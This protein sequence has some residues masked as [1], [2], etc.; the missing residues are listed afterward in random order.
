MKA[1]ASL[2]ATLA[3]LILCPRS[4]L[5]QETGAQKGSEIYVYGN[6]K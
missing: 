3:L 5:A 6:L 2:L 4:L 1:T